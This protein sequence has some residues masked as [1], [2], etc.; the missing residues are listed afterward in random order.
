MYAFDH[1][2]TDVEMSVF[3]M[4]S[5]YGE[6][7]TWRHITAAIL[8][9]RCTAE[10]MIYRKK[11]DG[12][13]FVVLYPPTASR[14]RWARCD[15]AAAVAAAAAIGCI[16]RGRARPRGSVGLLLLAASRRIAA[17]DRSNLARC[18]VGG[19]GWQSPQ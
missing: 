12:H 10:L 18:V 7:N 2:R 19:A 11:I 3:R 13:K 1:Y 17:P 15:T 9:P 14:A 6:C 4:V 8:T 16:V 5:L